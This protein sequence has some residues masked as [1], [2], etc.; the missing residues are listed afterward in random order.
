MDSMVRE[1]DKESKGKDGEEEGGTP[2]TN[3]FVNNN[4]LLQLS[5]HLTCPPNPS[6]TLPMKWDRRLL[7]WKVWAKLWEINGYGGR[8]TSLRKGDLPEIVNA[9]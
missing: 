1:D 3:H 9:L 6:G 7:E 5:Q 8:A 4:L 2:T